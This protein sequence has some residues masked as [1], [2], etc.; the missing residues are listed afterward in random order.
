MFAVR[1]HLRDIDER[2]LNDEID[3]TGPLQS[4]GAID[5]SILIGNTGRSKRRIFK[6]NLDLAVYRLHSREPVYFLDQLILL[7]F[8]YTASEAAAPEI[9]LLRRKDHTQY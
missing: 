2:E 9:F 4:Y 7:S 1:R 6:L 8:N 3:L 5:Q